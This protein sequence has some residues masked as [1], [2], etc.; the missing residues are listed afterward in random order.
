MKESKGCKLCCWK[1]IFETVTY[2]FP[3]DMHISAITCTF[4]YIAITRITS[5]LKIGRFEHLYAVNQHLLKPLLYEN[6]KMNSKP[7]FYLAS[8]VL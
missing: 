5:I 6:K 2:P 8:V 4:T 7:S 3:I 1:T